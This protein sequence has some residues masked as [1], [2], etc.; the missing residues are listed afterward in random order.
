[1]FITM[2]QGGITMARHKKYKTVQEIESIIDGYFKSCFEPK[3][4]KSGN[5]ITIEGERQRVQVKPF[6][7]GGLAHALDMSRQSLLN[8]QK[9]DRF[10]DTIT[11]AKRRCEVYAE[12]S[13][14]D[15]NSVQGAKFTLINN[16]PNWEQWKERAEVAQ[17]FYDMR[18][19]ESPR[20]E[21]NRRI[22]VIAARLG[23]EEDI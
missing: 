12:E 7:I 17:E 23:T 9:D 19:V 21:I 10:F 6:T 4:D 22:A 14:F 11:R 15:R 5:P 1:M 3:I 13:L 8:Y 2:M 18:K 20:D 16:Y